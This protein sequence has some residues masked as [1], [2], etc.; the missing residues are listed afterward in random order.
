M[1]DFEDYYQL[2][3][4]SSTATTQEIR[5][6][7]RDKSFILHP[8][9]LVG[10][11]ESAQKRAAEELLRVNRAYDVLKDPQQRREYHVE[12]VKRKSKPIPTVSPA[13]IDFDNLEPREIRKASFIVQNVGGPYA[14][15]WIANP[16]SWVKVVGWNSVIS[17]QELPLQVQIEVKGSEWGKTDS[18]LIKVKL[19]EEETQVTVK[20]R[21]KPHPTSQLKQQPRV[22]SS[23]TSQPARRRLWLVFLLIGFAALITLPMIRFV[24][25]LNRLNVFHGAGGKIVFQSDRDGNPEIYAMDS[26]GTNQTRLTH[27]PVPNWHPVWSTDGIKIAFQSDRDGNSEIYSMNADGSN[28]T[29]LTDNPAWD[30]YPTW[31]PDSTKIAF[32][33]DDRN[34]N[35]DI[36]IMNADGSNKLRLTDNPAPDYYPAWSPDGAKIAFQSDRDGNPEIYIMNAD[37]SSQTRLTNNPSPDWYPTWSPDGSK[38]AF[39]SDRDGHPEIYSMNPNGSSQTRLTLNATPTQPNSTLPQDAT[40]RSDTTETAAQSDLYDNPATYAWSPDSARISFQSERDGNIEI[41]V[42]EINNRKETR[43]TNNPGADRYPTWS[44]DGT[45]IAFQ[46]DRE[47]TPAIYVMNMDGSNQTRLTN[48]PKADRC[49]TWSPR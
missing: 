49:P 34:G 7:Y 9:R 38:L 37:G 29:R 10:A 28:Q 31:S 24:M 22:E 48:N 40:A 5:S 6:A 8:D 35:P 42:I 26:D 44:P 32:Q 43:L 14:K 18:E 12:W 25:G 45:Q 15:K 33:S 1:V 11:P 19:D 4:V 16:G 3:G 30:G 47:D 36:Y 21:M 13:H 27:N 20:L 23:A 46:S 17:S 41:Y 39:Q 2:L